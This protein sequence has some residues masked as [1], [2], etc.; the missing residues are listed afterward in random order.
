MEY[1]ISKPKRQ[2]GDDE[3]IDCESAI[4]IAVR[5]LV[6]AAISVG[7]RPTIVYEALQSV[8]RNQAFAYAEDPDPTDDP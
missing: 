6:D 3:Q 4:D 5:D 2:G 1:T 8:A 7:W